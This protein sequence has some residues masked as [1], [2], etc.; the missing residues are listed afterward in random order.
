MRAKYVEPFFEVLSYEVHV[1]WSSTWRGVKTNTWL[2]AKAM[3][4]ISLEAE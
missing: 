3:H 4:M 1:W 2:H